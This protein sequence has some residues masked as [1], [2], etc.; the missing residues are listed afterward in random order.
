MPYV[1]TEETRNALGDLT[2]DQWRKGKGLG[3][4]NNSDGIGHKW[5]EKPLRDIFAMGAAKSSEPG[6][7]WANY[8]ARVLER[9]MAR[10]A[11]E[12]NSELSPELK[13]K[14]IGGVFGTRLEEKL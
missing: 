8:W 11:R 5:N 2:Y 13:V 3:R 7:T 6:W 9:G 1:F 14:L 4:C 10:F 12:R